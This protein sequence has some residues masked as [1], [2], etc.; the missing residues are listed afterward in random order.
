M[1]NLVIHPKLQNLL[2]PLSEQEYAGLEKDILE[3]GC[4]SPI[5][6][7]NETIVDG[8]NRYKICQ[9]HGL[10]F[11]IKRLEFETLD[12]ACYWAWTH[13]DNRRNL[14]PFQKIELALQFKPQ[15]E[16]QARERQRGGRGGVLLCQTPDKA[17]D[18]KKEIA[19]TAGISHDTVHKAEFL[20]KHADEETKE[21][22]RQGK[23][24]INRE[25][26]RVKEKT[27]TPQAPASKN[28]PCI[29]ELPPPVVRTTLKGIRQDA[30][31]HLINSLATHF[32]KG[33]INE[34]VIKAMAYLHEVQGE[35]VATSIAKEIAGRYLKEVSWDET[36]SEKLYPLPPEHCLLRVDENKKISLSVAPAKDPIERIPKSVYLHA[37]PEYLEQTMIPSM[38]YL[39]QT[40]GKDGMADYLIGLIQRYKLGREIKNANF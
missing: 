25:Y 5:V 17:I 19:K 39:Y 11:D 16:K 12:D 38:D 15:I 3:N 22:L 24:T 28:V 2:P 18:T 37:G 23:T 31:D 8:H 32:R 34:L 7:W 6:T 36:V 30:P 14:T 27:A 4:L 21:N 13:Q 40:K 29:E 10:P 1:T 9:K 35:E 33:Y 26:K 20:S